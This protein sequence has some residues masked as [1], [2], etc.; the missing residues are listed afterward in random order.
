LLKVDLFKREIVRTLA[1]VEENEND[2]R[3]KNMAV[4]CEYI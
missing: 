4:I 3:H 1:K 2:L